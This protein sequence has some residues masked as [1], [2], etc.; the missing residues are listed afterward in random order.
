MPYADWKQHYQTSATAAQQAA[1]TAGKAQGIVQSLHRDM[2]LGNPLRLW[3]QHL[4]LLLL[5]ALF[6]GGCA[7]WDRRDPTKGW[8]AQQLYDSAKDLLEFGDYEKAIDYYSKLNTRYP[9]HWHSRSAGDA[10][11]RLCLL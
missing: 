4:L 1:Y 9:T 6:L 7:S 11:C 8:S 3:S 2:R 5:L 10:G